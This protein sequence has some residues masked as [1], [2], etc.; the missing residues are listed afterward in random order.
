[1]KRAFDIVVAAFGLLL[2]APLLLVIW[3]VVRLTLGSPAMFRQRRPGLHGKL[4]EMVKFRTM[5]QAVDAQGT[6]LPDEQRMTRL[7][8]L[9]RSTSLDELPELWN[10]LKGDMSLVGPRPLLP[11]Y[12]PLY[13]ARQRRRHEVRPG[14][15]GWAQV[16]G[17]NTLP[18][19]D[20]LEMDVWYVDNQ[21]QWLDLRIMGLTVVRVLRRHGISEQGSPTMTPFMG[22]AQAST[23]PSPN[24]EHS[25][26]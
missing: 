26:A 11:Q 9:L 23:S 1:M 5:R 6:P 7:G 22:A 17:R 16:N 25:D 8:S 19:P 10:V 15:T 12:L 20:R 21:S 2:C 4:F 18:W 14:V 13:S 3:G 24:S